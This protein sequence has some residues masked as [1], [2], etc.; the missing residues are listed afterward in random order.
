M[1]TLRQYI[2]SVAPLEEEACRRLAACFEPVVYPRGHRLF[3]AGRTETRMYFL[4][5]GIARAFC[6]SADGEEL[7]FWF[8]MEG[9]IVLSYNSY[10]HNRP[11][12]EHVELLEDS[13]LWAAS[14]E[15]VR[16]LYLSDIDIANWARKLAEQELI[17]TE[18][19]FIS[20]QT[21]TALERYRELLRTQPR[22][23]QRVPLGHIASYLGVTQVT[24][25][26]IRA[27]VRSL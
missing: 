21:G 22:L 11:G 19:R 16:K 10:I 4:E 14:I 20:R 27:E 5:K 17:R 13:R 26:R 7:S 1:E 25:S 12:Y 8:G 15:D 6:D 2:R 3:S 24:L 18:E 9:D 23:L